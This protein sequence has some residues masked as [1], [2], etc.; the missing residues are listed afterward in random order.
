V[1]LVSILSLT[2]VLP[3]SW[4]H[5]FDYSYGRSGDAYAPGDIESFVTRTRSDFLP[6]Y[7][8][9][10]QG[11][12]DSFRLVFRL[13]MGV[14]LFLF[15]ISLG[16]VL[17]FVWVVTQS[18]ESNSIGP[19][20]LSTFA[21]CCVG[22]LQYGV[23]FFVARLC[24]RFARLRSARI[25]N[26]AYND[27]ADRVR[28]QAMQRGIEKK[29]EE[30]AGEIKAGNNAIIIV[31]SRTG[32]IEQ[33]VTIRH[34]LRDPLALLI[35]YAEQSGNQDAIDASKKLV[36]EAANAKPDKGKIFKLWNTVVAAIPMLVEIGEAVMKLVGA[37]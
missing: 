30:R 32:N 17:V 10:E 18:G 22:A 4:G 1:A 7:V 6:E 27:R 35:A 21:S 12:L 19:F 3:V 25:R 2:G 34:D 5:D 29:V 33:T 11:I 23:I 16:V 28:L 14:S 20:E 36:A 9:K 31:N 15:T 26:E 37:A 13:V 24:G 8:S